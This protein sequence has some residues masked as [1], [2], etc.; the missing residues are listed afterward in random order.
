MTQWTLG[1]GSLV[2]KYIKLGKFVSVRFSFTAG[3]TTTFTADLPTFSLPFAVESSASVNTAWA[4]LLDNS[5]NVRYMTF[6]YG[7]TSSSVGILASDVSSTYG[8]QAPLGISSTRPFT[9]AVNDS[10]YFSMNYQAA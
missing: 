5:A 3:S 7:P 4:Q 10:I 2:G 9:W 1:N 6:V 8:P